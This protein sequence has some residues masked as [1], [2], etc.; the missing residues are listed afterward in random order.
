MDRVYTVSFYEHGGVAGVWLKKIFKSE[1]LAREYADR[2][3][4]EQENPNDYYVVEAVL[5]EDRQKSG[6]DKVD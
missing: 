4:A 2:K 3:N 1:S 6:D 5:L